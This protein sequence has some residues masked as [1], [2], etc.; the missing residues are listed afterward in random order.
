MNTI[1]A[2]TMKNYDVVVG[3]YFNFT[4]KKSRTTNL[5][6]RQHHCQKQQRT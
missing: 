3:M 4:R 5:N 2:L 6:A 1:N